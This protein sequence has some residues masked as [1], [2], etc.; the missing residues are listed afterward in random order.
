MPVCRSGA[1][2]RILRGEG[3]GVLGRNFSRGGVQAH[4]KLHRPI[5]LL[6]RHGSKKK[7][8]RGDV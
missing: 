2:L 8:L 3:G 6:Y 7:P 4:G 5:S 1:D